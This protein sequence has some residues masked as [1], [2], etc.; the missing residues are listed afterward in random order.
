M[1]TKAIHYL[2]I[3]RELKNLNSTVRCL[4]IRVR[5]LKTLFK[6]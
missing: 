2:L 5:C 4:D 3:K 6:W 1:K